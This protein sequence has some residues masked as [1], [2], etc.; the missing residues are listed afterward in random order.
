MKS[1]D[2]SK[3]VHDNV[4]HVFYLSILAN[5]P[6]NLFQRTVIEAHDIVLG[7]RTLNEQ[8]ELYRLN[9][10]WNCV[11]RFY[12]NVN[13]LIPWVFK[14]H[15]TYKLHFLTSCMIAFFLHRW[16]NK[17][18][19]ALAKYILSIYFLFTSYLIANLSI[20]STSDTFEYVFF[21]KF[22]SEQW[23]FRIFST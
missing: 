14:F 22:E 20:I 4:D 3:H 18:Q 6:K 17:I 8:F 10:F 19:I 2:P 5:V 9:L 1:S 12:Y 11:T 21:P 13:I 23:F 7:K 15:C 16:C